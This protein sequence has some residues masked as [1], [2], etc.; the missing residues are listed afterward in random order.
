[1]YL[2]H[3]T[4]KGFKSFASATLF[5]FEPG[6]TA[7]VGPNGS[8]K[9]NVVDALA[10]VMGE[11]GA[12]SLRG[13]KMTDVIFAGTSGRPALGRA[14]VKL[15][16]DNTDGTLP[17]DFTEVTISRTLFRTGGSEYAINGESV[18]LLDVQ[19]L[20]SDTGMGREMHVIVGQGQLDQILQATPEVR[21]GFVEEAAG[22]L[23]HRRRREKAVR[24]LE[25]TA[26]NL[27]RL[28]DLTAE[29]R[30]QLKPLGRQA[31]VARRAATIQAE[32]RDARARLLADDLT[33]AML[34]VESDKANAVA[35][36]ERRTRA[37]A[38]LA[39]A[40]RGLAEV[41]IALEQLRPAITT[42]QE[43]WYGL[44]SLAER[45]NTTVSISAE[46]M[47]ISAE[48]PLQAQGRDPEALDTEAAKVAEQEKELV[49][50]VAAAEQRLAES[51]A[52][53]DEA[54][55]AE[56]EASLAHAAALRAAAD[57]REGLAKLNGRIASLHS[58]IDAGTEE[59]ARLRQRR[60]DALVRA[61]KAD[62]RFSALE[63]MLGKISG[64]ESD[65][66]A[67]HVAATDELALAAKAQEEHQQALHEA[68][69]TAATL[70]ARIEALELGMQRRDASGVLLAIG[71]NGLEGAL[72]E[73]IKVPQQWRVA[74]SAVL[75]AMADA[76]VVTEMTT[77][78]DLLDMLRAKDLGTA[79]LLLADAPVDRAANCELPEGVHHALDVVEV[80]A[81]WGGALT[82]L[83][84]GVVFCEDTR[85]H[86][87][88]ARA[89]PRMT[90]VDC[91]GV[92][93][94][95]WKVQGGSA[96]QPSTI[97][98]GATIE[99]ARS[100]LEAAEHRIQLLES[101]AN[102]LENRVAGAAQRLDES[103][104]ALHASDARMSA[105]ADELGGLGQVGTAARDEAQR[106]EQAIAA[107]E[108]GI[109]EN[110]TVLAG[111]LERLAAAERDTGIA[112]PDPGERDRAV[113]IA[114][115]A[116]ATEMESR[117]ALRTAQERQRSLAGRAD[118]LRRAAAN[119]RA[120]RA[121]AAAH[122]ERM[123]R[124]ARIA[125]AVNTGARWLADQVVIARARADEHRSS[126][127]EQRSRM[128]AELGHHR[129]AVREKSAMLEQILSGE[130]QDQLNRL[131]LTMKLDALRTRA[132]EE[133]AMDAD[134]LV[135]DYGPEVPI[136]VL[137]HPDGSAIGPSDDQV[138]E[139]IPFVRTEQEKRL[140]AATRNL[141]AL[142]KVNPLALEEFEAM[143]ERHD[144]LSTQLE[145]LR[146][147]RKDLLDI[148]DE[149]DERVQEV[150]AAAYLDVERAFGEV[151]A[152]LFPGGEGRLVLTDPDDLLTTGIDVEARP[153]GKKVKRLSLLSGGERSLVAVAFL[154]SLFIA[155]PSPFYILDE[156]EAAL[157][158]V[159]LGR[160]LGIYKDLR[161]SSQLLIITHHKRTME[162]A[163][164]LYGV[165][166]RGDGVS[167]VISQRTSN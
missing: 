133:M 36:A 2:K 28:T 122:A 66:D 26:A 32:V 121:R 107:A 104:E 167:R 85:E 152:R 56:E 134:T 79:A 161:R 135:A 64:G 142:G 70:K 18:R 81:Q 143:T 55:R 57:R 156:V 119:E 163:D 96:Q 108:K 99:T 30:R 124:E 123:R 92:V 60:D 129:A 80:D 138:P 19:E 128:E 12:K 24:K 29:V 71:G 50:E 111:L 126:L 9:S 72:S 11:Q 146:T 23:K 37:E 139:P 75:G 101:K 27:A 155:R 159:N 118:S 46:R 5:D 106:A 164:A 77:G 83:L 132:M 87:D 51:L 53:R 116:R 65:L 130:H 112:D 3:L 38:D 67:A 39:L 7:I 147:T 40:R 127:E 14:E 98:I 150:F 94:S 86:L 31:E 61:E 91:D 44:A 20:L 21:R 25:S 35:L 84:D 33:Q 103:L 16:I 41:E 45:V 97:E 109:A 42:A 137:A 4:I 90:L 22:V 131:E 76:L 100:E 17:I 10:W 78:L 162:V 8:G 68:L 158:D 43:T 59:I 141:D 73:W 140:R 115:A 154:I 6:I 145:D 74:V 62:H 125:R 120:A 136:P 113:V 148:I 15:T 105:L 54:E 58:R 149:V 88:L 114:R 34:A 49:A 69:S 102:E 82:G 52:E 144:F 153:A 93:V 110:E 48:V 160:L 117:L 13:G 165:T 63:V 95:S 157:D 151:F 89:H 1:M 166:M 47:R